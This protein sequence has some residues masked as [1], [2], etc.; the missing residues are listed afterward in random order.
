M[1]NPFVYGEVVPAAAFVDR[2]DELKRL[3]TDL[4]SGQK[5]FLISPRRYG[6]SSLMR[7]AFDVLER[8]GT[9]TVDVTVS[10]YSSYVAF[11]EGYARAVLSA[12]TRWERALVWLREAIGVTRPEV[13]VERGARGSTSIAVTFPAMHGSRDVSRLAAEVFELPDRLA[14]ERRR[15]VVVALDEFQAIHAFN[16]GS[17]EETLRAAVQRHRQTG[18]VFA[19]SEPSLMERMIGPRRPFYKAGPVMRLGKIPP[20]VFAPFIESRFVRSGMRVEPGF[21]VAVLDLAGH[22]PYDVQRLAHETWDDARAARLKRV[23]LEHLHETLHRL[24]AEQGLVYESAW[25]RLTLAQ[26]SALRAVVLEE[27]RE[28]LSADTRQRHRLGGASTVQAALTALAREDL[29]T[30]DASRWVVVDSL[31]REWIARR[32]Y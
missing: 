12:A 10:S 27:G 9:L 29:V 16:G 31:M 3:V 13:R 2:D 26:R 5:V 19:G 14:A 28:L 24:L 15:P 32:T 1:N 25:Q 21:G 18:Y 30:R 4:A 23:G 11:L 6:K 8:R 17:V 7:R 20:D 22:L